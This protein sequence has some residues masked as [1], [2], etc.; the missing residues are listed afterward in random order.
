MGKWD[1]FS[2]DV[3][4]NFIKESR[5]LLILDGLK[6]T[7][8]LSIT[9][10]LFGIVLGG[11]ATLLRRSKYGFLRAIGYT[12]VDV[13]RGTPSMMQL[14]VI[15][16]VVFASVN[17]DLFVVGTV[18]FGLNSGAYIS[19]IFRAG[20]LSIDKGQTE[21][22]RSL[23]LSS[24]QTMTYIILP[25]AIKNILPALANEFIMLIKE[26]AIVGYIAMRDLTKAGDIIRSLTY[27]AYMPLLAV[28][29]LYY[30]LVK[31]LTLGIEWLERYL[32]ASDMR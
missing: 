29:L 12:Y 13:I 7:I 21:A 27:D 6:T 22:G 2:H 10:I 15:N 25:Q 30:L 8:L 14:L 17:V 3:Y 23:G 32:R 18:A 11:L 31:I 26:T 24:S 19:E 16:F 28:A 1:A 4:L 20:I 9:A 5:Y